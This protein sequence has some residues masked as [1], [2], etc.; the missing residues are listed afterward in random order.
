MDYRERYRKDLQHINNNIQFYKYKIQLC[1]AAKARMFYEKLLNKELRRYQEIQLQLQRIDGNTKFYDESKSMDTMNSDSINTRKQE[2]IDNSNIIQSAK[3]R[4]LHTMNSKS[5]LPGEC[6]TYPSLINQQTLQH[7][8]NY[9]L[10]NL[11]TL[12]QDPPADSQSLP[13]SEPR[14]FTLEELAQFNGEGGQPAY[15][16]VNGIVYD[17]TNVAPWKGG[18]HFRLKAGND[19]TSS[20]QGCHSGNLSQLKNVPIVGSLQG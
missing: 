6:S 2:S 20:F 9:E 16:A 11:T 19:L 12:A 3:T 1:Q 8:Q 13:G 10:P 5:I 18:T 15:V 7:S 14:I 17:V 4:S